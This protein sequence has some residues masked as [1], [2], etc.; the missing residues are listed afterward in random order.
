MNVATYLPLL[1]TWQATSPLQRVHGMQN[2]YC[3]LASL[4]L[5]PAKTFC[6]AVPFPILTVQSL[7]QGLTTGVRSNMDAVPRADVS[8]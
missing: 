6:S 7:T 5:Q 3:A 4:S 2:D 8:P 1:T